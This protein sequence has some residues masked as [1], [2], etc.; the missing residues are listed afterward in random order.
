M[1]RARTVLICHDSEPLNRYGLARWMAS[2]SDLAGI[3]EIHEPFSR[4]WKRA[5]REYQR[6]GKYRFF[7][8]LAFRLYSRLMLASKD[9]EWEDRLLRSLEA[10]YP[11]LPP[12]TRILQTSSPNS[13]A[14]EKLLRELQP[15]IIIA[16]C[17]FILNARIFKQARVGTF[18]MHPGIC[19]EYRN[20]HGC[21]WA[22]A[23]RDIENVG[24][25]L[26]KVDEGVDTGPVYGYYRCNFDEACDTHNMIQNKTVFENLDALRAKL[27]EIMRGSAHTIDTRGRTSE[28]WGQPWFSSY[29]R[30]KRMA[31]KQQ[32][33][34]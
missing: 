7:D 17:K 21:F 11:S 4:T 12:S 33:V 32:P 16:R 24:M 10:Q 29:L 28:A 30:W 9:R 15:D 22:L 23:R 6:V 3:V 1:D 14:T 19:P 34:R 13:S 31:Q 5:K 25:T 8:V 26:L 2:F 18:V 27:E 20:A